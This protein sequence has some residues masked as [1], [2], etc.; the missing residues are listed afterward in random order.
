MLPA[1]HCVSAHRCVP[2]HAQLHLSLMTLVPEFEG[3][4]WQADT[5]CRGPKGIVLRRDPRLGQRVEQRGFTHIRQADDS[6]LQTHNNSFGSN[7]LHRAERRLGRSARPAGLV[8]GKQMAYPTP[9]LTG[10]CPRFGEQHLLCK[11]GS[12]LHAVA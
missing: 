6:A 5:L 1:V 10:I 3:Q 11:T 12:D 8:R 9:T 2:L 4:K 7:P